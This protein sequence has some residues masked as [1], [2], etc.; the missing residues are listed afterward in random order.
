MDDKSQRLKTFRNLLEKRKLD[1][2]LLK[3]RANTYWLTGFTGSTSMLLLTAGA[4]Y[5]IVDFRYTLQARKQVHPAVIVIEMQSSFYVALEKLLSVHGLRQIGYEGD[6]LTVS[7]FEQLRARLRSPSRWVNIADDIPET[8]CKKDA[9]EICALRKA[10]E[11]SDQAFFAIL[12]AIK[13]NVT[14]LDIAAE[15]AYHIQKLGGDALAFDSI[16][17]SGPNA[18][19]CHATVSQRKLHKGDVLVMDF[20]AK[21][22]GYCADMTR[23]VFLGEPPKELRKIYNLVLQAQ[24]AALSAI[25]AGM[26]GKE[27]DAISRNII[28]RAGYGHCFGHSLGHGLGLAIHEEPRLAATSI[29][30]LEDGMVFTVEPGIY[31]EGLGGVRIEDMGMLNN[32]RFENFTTSQKELMIL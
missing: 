6:V 9:T 22:D 3:G 8:R 30:V 18:A 27:V 15:M 20:G 5:L 11:V 23:T 24:L 29:D 7:D 31:L 13:E 14:E 16:I 4:A 28:T 10:A 25:R 26:L 12:P 2:L 32:G 21:V 1:A 19:L 17:A